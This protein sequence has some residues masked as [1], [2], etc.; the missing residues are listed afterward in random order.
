MPAQPSDIKK[1]L[2]LSWFYSMS[3]SKQKDAKGMFAFVSQTVWS[4]VIKFLFCPTGLPFPSMK[5]NIGPWEPL[6]LSQTLLNTSAASLSTYRIQTEIINRAED[7]NFRLIAWFIWATLK[8]RQLTLSKNADIFIIRS[9]KKV[10]FFI[11]SELI[12][13]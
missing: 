2:T 1:R 7:V 12:V 5:N 6:V 4:L 11:G 8:E 13:F 3:I 9:V 10:C